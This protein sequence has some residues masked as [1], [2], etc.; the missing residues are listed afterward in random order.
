[1]GRG[2]SIRIM[3]RGGVVAEHYFPTGVDR[4]SFYEPTGRGFEK[5]IWE[6]LESVRKMLI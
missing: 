2:I 3:L 1:M 4:V 6:R 5:E